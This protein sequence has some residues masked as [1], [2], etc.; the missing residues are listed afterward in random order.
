MQY[1]ITV[2][3]LHIASC[4]FAFGQAPPLLTKHIDLGIQIQHTKKTTNVASLHEVVT[5]DNTSSFQID[6]RGTKLTETAVIRMT[7]VYDGAVQHLNHS[8]LVQ[9]QYKSAWFNGNTVVVELIEN[10]NGDSSKLNI[11]QAITFEQNEFEQSICGG[12]DDRELSYEARTARAMPI[13][14]TA[15]IIDDVNRTFLSAGH[16]SS[17]N[18]NSLGIMQFNVPLSDANGN[19]QH[20]GPEDQYPVDV[21]SIQYTP[22]TYIGNDWAYFGCFPNSETGLTPYEAQQ[23]YFELADEAPGVNGQQ[24]RITGHGT[25]SAPVSNTWNGV[26]KTHVGPFTQ[27]EDNT[28]AYYTD[29]TGGNS[30]SAVL[31]ESTGLAIGIHTNGGCSSSSNQNHGCAIHNAGLQKA[32]ANPQGV[33]IPNI[34][35][36]GFP[37]GVPTQTNPNQETPIYFNVGPGT[38][39]PVV[40]SVMLHVSVNGDIMSDPVEHIGGESYTATLPAVDCGDDVTFWFSATGSA[41]DTA[42]SPFN[43]EDAPYTLVVGEIVKVFL[44]LESFDN[45]LPSDWTLDGLWN[46]SSTC[47]PNGDCGEAPFMYF[48]DESSCTYDNG[49]TVSGLLNSPTYSFDDAVSEVAVSFCYA[50]LTESSS[51]YDFASVYANGTLVNEL[52]DSEDWSTHSFSAMPDEDGMLNLS[53]GF[54]SIDDVFNDFRGFHIDNVQLTLVTVECDDSSDCPTDVNGDAMTN[55]TDLLQVIDNWGQNGGPAD[56]NQDGTVN[57]SDVLLIVSE[58]GVCE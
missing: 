37:N 43:Y 46:A 51:S 23:S 33:C 24:I 11:H 50:L 44:S 40:D 29:T 6:F 17:G 18:G 58:W 9:W 48:G 54:D 27:S 52:S 25:T 21:D 19:Y 53:W 38:Q 1:L 8:S 15:W 55:V 41:G 30:G 35:Q 26:Q 57:V 12:V 49:N 36:F 3:F 10:G 56:V 31:D 28:I 4:T 13:G 2:L 22:D 42:Y 39:L 5:L 34:L 45:G 20:P 47:I 32:L 16:C 14:C 7:S